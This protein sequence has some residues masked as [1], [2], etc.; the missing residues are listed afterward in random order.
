[1]KE[2]K[3]PVAQFFHDLAFQT[4]CY[5]FMAYGILI[6]I[7]DADQRRFFREDFKKRRR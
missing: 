2:F 6:S 1:M 3:N 4:A 5:A 7:F